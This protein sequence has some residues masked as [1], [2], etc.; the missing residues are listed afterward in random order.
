MK[1]AKVRRNWRD[2][3]FFFS[4]H[5]KRGVSTKNGKVE[6]SER[7]I[8]ITRSIIRLQLT[9]NELFNEN[10]RDFRTVFSRSLYRATIEERRKRT[11]LQ[12]PLVLKTMSDKCPSVRP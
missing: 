2:L 3:G 10:I 8:K 1:L 5:K 9:T 7:L 11:P 4:S 12:D 6:K